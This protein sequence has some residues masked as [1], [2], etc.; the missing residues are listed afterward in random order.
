VIT[1]PYKLAGKPVGVLGVIGPARMN[2]DHVIPV[3]D[4]T[5]RLLGDALKG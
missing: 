5:A 1:A 4:M 3:V 2:Y